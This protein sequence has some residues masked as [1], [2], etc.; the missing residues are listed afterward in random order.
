[1]VDTKKL[2]YNNMKAMGVLKHVLYCA[3]NGGDMTE[4]DMVTTL[5]VVLDYLIENNRIFNE[6]T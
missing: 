3:D 5:E 1:M 4:L 2:D 6:S